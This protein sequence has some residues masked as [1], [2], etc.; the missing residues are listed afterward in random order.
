MRKFHVLW[1]L[2]VIFFISY[3]IKWTSSSNIFRIFNGSWLFITECVNFTFER[4][5]NVSISLSVDQKFWKFLNY[6]RKELIRCCCTKLR[7]PRLA[8]ELRCKRT[9]AISPPR[10]MEIAFWEYRVLR[11]LSQFHL[12]VICKPHSKSNAL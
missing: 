12:R 8:G 11:G 1:S 10:Y 7:I 9:V 5:Q 3:V 4:R 6:V 2:K